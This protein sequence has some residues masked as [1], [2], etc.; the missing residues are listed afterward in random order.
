[1]TPR[2]RGIGLAVVVSVWWLSLVV[3]FLRY[4]GDDVGRLPSLVGDFLSSLVRNPVFGA[5]GLLES[6]GGLLLAG[7]AVLAWYGLGDLIA[8]VSPS[9][10]SQ[11]GGPGATLDLAG[12]F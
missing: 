5:S 7:L 8:R 12:R 9:S 3:V 4:R 11:A 10:P 1:M 2:A 6:I